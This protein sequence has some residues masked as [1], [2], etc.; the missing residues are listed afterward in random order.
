[1][2]KRYPAGATGIKMAEPKVGDQEDGTQ[3]TAVTVAGT[4]ATVT[5][6]AR[7]PDLQLPKA[8]RSR[9]R[10]PTVCGPSTGGGCRRRSA[11]STRATS[12]ARNGSCGRRSSRTPAPVARSRERFTGIRWK[13]FGGKVATG[14]GRLRQTYCRRGENCPD[15]GRRIRLV[16]S[17]PALLQGLRQD[18]VPEAGH[19][20]RPARAHGHADSLRLTY[21]GI[22]HSGNQRAI[23]ASQGM[24]SLSSWALTRSSDSLSRCLSPGPGT[25]G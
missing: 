17:K 11:S 8:S 15:N 6:V 25:N 9:G 23:S 2:V 20:P 22:S 3:V 4:V 14:Y 7:A 18:R 19:L 24:P 16:A 1:M 10:R 12:S 21:S 13:R 5:V